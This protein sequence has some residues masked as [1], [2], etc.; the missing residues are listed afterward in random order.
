MLTKRI[1]SGQKFAVLE[2]K[3]VVS[4]IIRNFKIIPTEKTKNLTFT[5]DLVMRPKGGLNIVLEKRVYE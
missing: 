1:F 5:T 3:A 2:M 4:S